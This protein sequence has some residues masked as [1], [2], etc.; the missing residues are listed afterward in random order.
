MKFFKN[1]FFIILLSIAIFATI[2]TATLSVMGVVDPIKDLANTVAAPLRSLG[3]L[4]ERSFDGF[5]RYFSAIDELDSENKALKGEID[6]L[7]S[8]LADADAVRE[9]NERLREYLEIKKTYP[10]FKMIEALIVSAESDNY[11]T[12]FTLDKGSADGVKLGMPIIVGEG[13]VGSVCEVGSSWSRV[14]TL[15]EASA[16]AGAYVS[17]SGE[18]G[19]VNGDISLK[20]TGNCRLQYIDADAD[21]QIGDLI[22]TSGLGS[23]Y[24]RGLFIGRI[25]SVETN[26]SLRT[27]N[28]TVELAV[29]TDSLRYVLVVTDFDVY[30]EE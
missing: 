8:Q 30:A 13:L 1:K 17:R 4:I 18:T 28:A 21:V 11:A 6:R 10:D 7:E 20:D 26:E 16:S 22:Y 29:D 9:E 5:S 3:D 23:V 15:A 25:V 12:F 19:V 27:K 14:R 2:L 24:P